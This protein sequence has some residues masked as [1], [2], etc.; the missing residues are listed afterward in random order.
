MEERID[1]KCG[2]YTH[3]P[4]QEMCTMC[5]S[6]LPW[7]LYIPYKLLL[8]VIAVT[9]VLVAIPVILLVVVILLL[10]GIILNIKK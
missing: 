9:V 8:T 2:R 1:C 3:S 6:R 5:E 10:R 7:F 4:L